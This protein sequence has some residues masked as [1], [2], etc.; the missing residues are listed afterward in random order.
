MLKKF[1]A[2]VFNEEVRTCVAVGERHRSFDDQWAEVHY[3]E[4]MASNIKDARTMA[5]R[6][7]PADKGFV[8]RDVEELKEYL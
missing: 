2:A 5:T 4:I 1:E 8:I 7:F 6:R 3:V